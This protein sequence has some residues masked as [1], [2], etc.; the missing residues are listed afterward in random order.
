VPPVPSGAPAAI[1]AV[2]RSCS[3]LVRQA[4]LSASAAGSPLHAPSSGM[5]PSLIS[6]IMHS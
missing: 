1:Q 2:S 5:V 4:E 6:T 3:S